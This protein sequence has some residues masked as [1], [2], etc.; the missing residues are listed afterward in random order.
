MNAILNWMSSATKLSAIS[1]S[2]QI[3]ADIICELGAKDGHIAGS[4]DL[5]FILII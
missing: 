1:L 2:D 3:G 4:D 5:F